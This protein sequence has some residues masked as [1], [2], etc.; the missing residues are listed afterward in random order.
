MR[1][2]AFS[3]ETHCVQTLRAMLK[4]F[5]VGNNGSFVALMVAIIIDL[6]YSGRPHLLVFAALPEL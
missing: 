4:I 6:S 3:V 2:D 5:Y 1:Q